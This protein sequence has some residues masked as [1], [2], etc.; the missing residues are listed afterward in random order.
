MSDAESEDRA[1][2][3]NDG[4]AFGKDAGVGDGG[5]FEEKAVDDGGATP[6]YATRCKGETRRQQRQQWGRHAC[7]GRQAETADGIE[8]DDGESFQRGTVHNRVDESHV[9]LSELRGARRR[10]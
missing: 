8:S 7:I 6:I 5:A 2:T 4:E 10:D 1:S 9:R 3:V